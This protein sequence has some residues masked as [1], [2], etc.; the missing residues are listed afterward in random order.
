MKFKT[1]NLNPLYKIKLYKFTWLLYLKDLLSNT[2]NLI[3]F[4]DAITF[5]YSNES[6]ASLKGSRSSTQDLMLES[7]K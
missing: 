5:D 6:S 7:F 4:Y 3:H 2:Y 1:A